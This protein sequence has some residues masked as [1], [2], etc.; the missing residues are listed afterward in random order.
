MFIKGTQLFPFSQTSYNAISYKMLH[1]RDCIFWLWI[2]KTKTFILSM[3]FPKQLGGS[4]L[5]SLPLRQ[6]PR[7][8]EKYVFLLTKIVLLFIVFL[9][10]LNF[11]SS[12]HLSRGL[13]NSTWVILAVHL[14]ETEID[15][16]NFHSARHLGAPS[17]HQS[18]IVCK[19]LPSH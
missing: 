3:W 17:G 5:P 11:D 18:S 13:G 1:R 2:K 7:Q 9:N 4:L 12:P 19:L 10:Q 6:A 16:G 15:L 14:P 8:I